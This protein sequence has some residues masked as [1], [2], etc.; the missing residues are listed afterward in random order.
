MGQRSH[1]LIAATSG[2]IALIVAVV[3]VVFDFQAAPTESRAET[4]AA[5]P[6]E[7]ITERAEPSSSPTAEKPSTPES[8]FPEQ[9]G[10]LPDDLVEVIPPAMDPQYCNDLSDGGVTCQ[11]P[12]G[13][14]ITVETG[15]TYRCSPDTCT[16]ITDQ[17]GST[18]KQA[19]LVDSP[20]NPP[21]YIQWIPSAYPQSAIRVTAAMGEYPEELVEWW[22]DHL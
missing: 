3:L 1:A 11:S 18:V 15:G 19:I 14:N 7:S 12:D 4:T 8:E 21:P 5:T 22:V 17:G 20:Q 9:S 6:E 13:H 16:D 2:V 10:G